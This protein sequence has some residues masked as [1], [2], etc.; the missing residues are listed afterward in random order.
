MALTFMRTALPFAITNKAYTYNVT[1]TY[2]ARSC[3]EN[4]NRRAKKQ[5]LGFVQLASL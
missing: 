5:E 1:N 2:D 4:R 3:D